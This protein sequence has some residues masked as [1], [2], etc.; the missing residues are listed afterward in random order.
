[1]SFEETEKLLDKLLN[2]LNELDPKNNELDILIAQR[3]L[4]DIADC[5]YSTF[6]QDH[7]HSS[8]DDIIDE[9]K[10]LNYNEKVVIVKYLDCCIGFMNKCVDDKKPFFY[11]RFKYILRLLENFRN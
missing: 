11:N 5:R 4:Y 6:I 1:M 2:I 3:S 10:I 7:L 8:D 9:F